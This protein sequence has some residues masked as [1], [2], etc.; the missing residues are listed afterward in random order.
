MSFGELYIGF[1]IFYAGYF[2]SKALDNCA[3][4]IKEKSE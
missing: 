4:S 3:K 2:I 1:A